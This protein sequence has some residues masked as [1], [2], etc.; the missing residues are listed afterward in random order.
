MTSAIKQNYHI[1]S[2]DSSQDAVATSNSH[3][4]LQ[5]EAGHKLQVTVNGDAHRAMI[6]N[7]F[8]AKLN[9]VDVEDL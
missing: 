3:W 8:V 6:N 2:I 7:F 9:D 5:N 4:F 1:W